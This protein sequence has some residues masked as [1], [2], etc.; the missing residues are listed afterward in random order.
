MNKVFDLRGTQ[1]VSPKLSHTITPSKEA[2]FPYHHRH[3]H[4][5]EAS[6]Y[7]SSIRHCL[8]FDADIV[9]PDSIEAA[10]PFLHGGLTRART[11]G[12][13]HIGIYVQ[14][15]DWSYDQA[16]S[17]NSVLRPAVPRDILHLRNI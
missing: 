8:Y 3:F 17:C 5:I 12:A 9:L 11:A 16:S 1:R 14:R 10:T 6:G 13:N 7:D 2:T 4:H 15:W